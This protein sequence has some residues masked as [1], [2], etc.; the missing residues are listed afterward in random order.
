MTEITRASQV[1]DSRSRRARHHRRVR[2]G[3]VVG[4]C[5]LAI[6]ATGVIY[7]LIW[8]ILSGFKNNAGLFGNAWAL[9]DKLRFSNYG[10]AIHQGI[11][12]YFIN[13]VLVTVC[14]TVG[15]LAISSLAAF[16]LTRL[17]FKGSDFLG[18]LLLAGMMLAP[19]VALIPL[20]R[21]FVSIHLYNT[22][23]GLVLVYIAYRLPFSTFLIR[24]YMLTLPSSL[25]ESARSDGADNWKIFRYIILP[26]CK[27]ALI[28]ASLLQ[29]IYAWNE[30]PFALAF[31]ADKDKMTLPV[32]LMQMNNALT[33]NWPVLFAGLTLAALPMIIAFILGQRHFVRG[34]A[35][36]MGK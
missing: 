15:V 34:L 7:P 33:T 1:R 10:E 16:A 2:P 36:G 32:G 35:E 17:P 24:A 26:L 4:W 19:A 28:S 27:P 9:P 6:L 22:Y 12:G 31:I 30:F 29:L 3:R 18:M 8:M 13:S 21:L 25:E 14:S 11:T 23:L 5:I 20:F